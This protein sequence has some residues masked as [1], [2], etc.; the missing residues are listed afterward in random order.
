MQF[1]KQRLIKEVKFHVQN[2]LRSGC[3]Y[4]E[5]SQHVTLTEVVISSDLSNI[6]LYV[7]WDKSI[8]DMSLLS[9]LRVDV[10]HLRKLIAEKIPF[11]KVPQL[12][13]YFD[14]DRDVFNQLTSVMASLDI[15]DTESV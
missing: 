6:K 9:D 10:F 5:K 14:D 1:R 3:D 7:H 13:F 8:V 4:V 15:K 12:K 2:W 11:K